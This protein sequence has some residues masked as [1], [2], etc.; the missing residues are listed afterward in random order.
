MVTF[1][2]VAEEEIDEKMEKKMKAREMSP[3]KEK[4]SN[5][6]IYF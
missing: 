3:E 2:Y 1:K 5:L 6:V 4:L